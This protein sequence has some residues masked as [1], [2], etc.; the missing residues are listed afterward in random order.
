MEKLS[1]TQKEVNLQFRKDLA[2]NEIEFILDNVSEEEVFKIVSIA[3]IAGAKSSTIVKKNIFSYVFFNHDNKLSFDMFEFFKEMVE[4]KKD[5]PMNS[6]RMIT[7]FLKEGIS[8][9]VNLARNSFLNTYGFKSKTRYAKSSSSVD[10]IIFNN[11]YNSFVK[12]IISSIR[13]PAL[14]RFP[15]IE[16][17]TN[18]KKEE[19]D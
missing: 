8:S 10:K 14:K 16:L 17:I 12:T 6:K 15:Y 5:L 19:W 2:S 7:F 18:S 11:F 9:S 13:N 3:S 1:K 4:L